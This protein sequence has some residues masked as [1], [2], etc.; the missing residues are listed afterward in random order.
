M[1]DW[2]NGNISWED[3]VQSMNKSVDN[4]IDKDI[5]MAAEALYKCGI[6]CT[7]KNENPPWIDLDPQKKELFRKSA[8]G[9][10]YSRH[11]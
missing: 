4:W 11:K 5:E 10:V 2:V 8:I 9:L 7:N 6:S 1:I 3:F